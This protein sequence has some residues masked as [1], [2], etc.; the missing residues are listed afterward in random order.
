MTVELKYLEWRLSRAKSKK[1]YAEKEIKVL[2][3]LIKKVKA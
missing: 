3:E 1:N 2:E